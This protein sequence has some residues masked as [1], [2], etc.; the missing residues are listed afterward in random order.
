MLILV[1]DAA[2]QKYFLLIIILQL[3]YF[4]IRG[5]GIGVLEVASPT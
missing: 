4:D 5:E 2:P 3:L 1:W